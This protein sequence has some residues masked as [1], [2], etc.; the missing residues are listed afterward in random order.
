VTP[1]STVDLNASTTR[2]ANQIEL[3]PVG[4]EVVLLQKELGA[5]PWKLEMPWPGAFRWRVVSRDDRGLEGRPSADGL[6]CVDEK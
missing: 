1:G 6:I 4:S 2:A 5:P 3:L